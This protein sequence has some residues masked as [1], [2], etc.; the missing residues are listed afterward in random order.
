MHQHFLE[1]QLARLAVDLNDKEKEEVDIEAE[2]KHT[3]HT[4][5]DENGSEEGLSKEEDEAVLNFYPRSKLF[6]SL[7]T[8]Y[9]HWWQNFP[10][11]NLV[12]LSFM[13]LML[14]MMMRM[15]MMK[16]II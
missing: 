15:I 6:S 3:S 9:I 10:T 12:K 13:V 16:M 11:E 4:L 1:E 2:E 7:L 14:M 5:K 8:R